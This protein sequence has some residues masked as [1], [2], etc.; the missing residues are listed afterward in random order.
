M[1]GWTGLALGWTLVRRV[2]ITMTARLATHLGQLRIESSPRLS[3]VRI[4][5]RPFMRLAFGIIGGAALLGV[6]IGEVG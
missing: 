1:Q 3:E 2:G 6:L 5:R 4:M